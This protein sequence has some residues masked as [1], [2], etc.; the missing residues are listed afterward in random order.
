M[1]FSLIVSEQ[2]LYFIYINVCKYWYNNL[3]KLNKQRKYIH[4]IIITYSIS[5]S[6][7]PIIYVILIA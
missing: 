5:Y 4:F 2:A 7:D 1:K 3:N 6:N